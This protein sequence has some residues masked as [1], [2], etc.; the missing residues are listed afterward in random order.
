VKKDE[1]L[2][3][4]KRYELDII[5]YDNVIS[6]AQQARAEK[7]KAKIILSGLKHQLRTKQYE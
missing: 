4:I 1:L 2:R 6:R 7:A 5:Q 3:W